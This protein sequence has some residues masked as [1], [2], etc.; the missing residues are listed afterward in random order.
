MSMSLLMNSDD[1]TE[2]GDTDAENVSVLMIFG[3]CAKETRN[4]LTLQVYSQICTKEDL[5]H[6]PNA[7]ELEILYNCDKQ[8]T[9]P[10]HF[11]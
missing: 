3:R 6:L 10:I 8:C 5:F 9:L 2:F 4:H 7:E 11:A 1:I